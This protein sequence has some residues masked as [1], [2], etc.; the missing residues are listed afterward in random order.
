[1]TISAKLCLL[2]G[3]KNGCHFGTCYTPYDIDEEF[4]KNNKE[5]L[6]EPR[7]NGYWLWKPYFIYEKMKSLSDGEI[8]IYSDAGVEFINDINHIINV[9]TED[10]FFFGNNYNHVDWCKGDTLIEILN[11][12]MLCF[13]DK[14]I[15]AS[16]IIFK[17]N[18]ETKAFV[19]QWL[20][21]CQD[22][23][24]IDDSPSELPNLDTFAEHRH[25]QA[26]LTCLA[27]ND[28]FSFHYWP[29]SYNDGAFHYEKIEQYKGD[30]Y[31][32]I[33]HHHRKRNN[34]WK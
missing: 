11:R 19:K 23:Q 1:M 33:F 2:S 26:I 8:L 21:Y 14:Q 18:N 34:E 28:G 31:P 15:Q 3:L 24:L 22:K 10:I 17:I 12:D 16:V 13:S 5:I 32:I 30:N 6:D 20:D 7:G 9:M 29:A 27:L 4:R 25:D